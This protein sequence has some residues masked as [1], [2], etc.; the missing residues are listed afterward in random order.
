MGRRKT[1]DMI[2]SEQ[3]LKLGNKRPKPVPIEAD[4]SIELAR[5]VYATN[6]PQVKSPPKIYLS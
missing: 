5:V 6:P 4:I 2:L 1:R 3:N